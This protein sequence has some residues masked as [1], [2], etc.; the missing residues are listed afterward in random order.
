VSSQA[1]GFH[2]IFIFAPQ[3]GEAHTLLL[4][5]G[6]GGN[7]QQLLPLGQAL[8]SSAN[9]LSVR[10]KVLE[11]GMPRF[12]RRFAEGIFD[13]EDIRLRAEELARFLKQA[14]AEYG[15]NPEKVFAVGF[16]NGANIAA[17]LLL[18]HTE[19]LAGAVLFR[20]MVPLVPAEVASLHGK[21]ILLLAGQRDPIVPPENVA[22]LAEMF[23]QAGAEVTL[24]TLRTGHGL[25]QEDV[26]FA[27]AWLAVESQKE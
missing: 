20:A 6:T 24:K 2:H 26:D 11:N 17:A 9:L 5:H 22:Q 1:D 15:L 25:T 10:G 23:V 21:P 7:E 4:L 18:L 8:A 16:S 14:T 27:Q 19:A 13:E 3:S 12:F